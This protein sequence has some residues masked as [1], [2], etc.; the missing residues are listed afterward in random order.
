MI[1]CKGPRF[2]PDII[3]T[4]VLGYLA[5]PLSS[6]NREERMAERGVA[7]DHSNIYRGV[8]KFTPHSEAAFQKGKR[9]ILGFED[10]RPVAIVYPTVIPVRPDPAV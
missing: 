3:L 2:E 8:Q 4:G 5:Y 6:R 10:M 7:V 9:L 1:D